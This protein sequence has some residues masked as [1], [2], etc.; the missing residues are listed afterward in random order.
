MNK[1][2]TTFYRLT[3]NRNIHECVAY[4]KNSKGNISLDKGYCKR[5]LDNGY[6]NKKSNSEIVS[7]YNKIIYHSLYYVM[8]L[9]NLR[10]VVKQEFSM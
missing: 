10:L 2:E 4:I 8:H 6:C 1:L 9:I 3:K 5:K 7:K